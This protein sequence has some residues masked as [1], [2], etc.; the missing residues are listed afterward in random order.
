MISLSKGK[1]IRR[2]DIALIA[3]LL[4]EE[5]PLPYYFEIVHFDGITEN[6]LTQHIDRVGKP[7]YLRGAL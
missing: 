5:S 6:E 2:E 3:D 1:E 7:I 4:N